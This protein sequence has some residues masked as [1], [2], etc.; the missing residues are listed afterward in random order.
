MLPIDEISQI[1]SAV[2]NDPESRDLL[3]PAVIEIVAEHL[4]SEYDKSYRI[5]IDGWVDDTPDETARTEAVYAEVAGKTFAERIEEYA[6]SDLSLFMG[7]IALL[8]ETDGHRCRS[9]GTLAAGNTL[10][11]V[12]LTVVKRWVTK[13]DQAVRDPHV[14]LEG[15]AV[16]LGEMFEIDGFHALAP[17]LF[18]V[19]ELDCNCRCELEIEVI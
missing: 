1:V 4:E 6:A 3:A 14:R 19:G 10:V 7:S 9:E 5:G 16:P 13:H 11:G 18:G 12:G 2:Q 15:K 8:M 17:G